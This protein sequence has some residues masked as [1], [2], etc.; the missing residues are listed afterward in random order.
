MGRDVD[1]DDVC[2]AN[3]APSPR[4]A[5]MTKHRIPRPHHGAR[6]TAPADRMG[7]R[8]RHRRRGNALLR[9]GTR[10][11]IIGGVALTAGFG[12]M[13]YRTTS[14]QDAA[15]AAAKE[16]V[17]ADERH[18]YALQ[19]AALARVRA[20]QEAASRA[21][22]FA[23]L[24]TAQAQARAH[25]VAA[26]SAAAAASAVATSAPTSTPATASASPGTVSAVSTSSPS[27][28]TRPSTPAATATPSATPSTPVVSSGG[29]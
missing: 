17:L 2:S 26:A 29:S 22:R 4:A 13:A 23:A 28:S 11:A 9:H 25:Q 24:R 10:V 1:P 27:A 5:P 16:R 8:L 6:R 19:Q 3:P 7:P 12:I 15:R 18:Q 21:A 20:Q 14:A